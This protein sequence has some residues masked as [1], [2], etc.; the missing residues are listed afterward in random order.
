MKALALMSGGLDST[1]AA[2]MIL[3]QGIEIEGVNFTSPFCLCNRKGRCEAKD[4]AEKLNIN[5]YVINVGK[6]YLNIIKNPKHGYGKNMN[7]CIDC[8]IFI[9]KKAKAI[10]K[11][12]GASFIFTGEVLDER[13]MSQRLHALKIIEKEAGLEGKILRPLSAKCLPET[14][15]EKKGWVDRRK[16]LNFKGRSRKNQIQLANNLGIKDYRCPAGGCLL[17]QKEFA[18]KLKDL[19]NHKKRIALKDI[20]LLKL[21]RHFRFGQNKI[22]VGRN[23]SENN[24]LKNLKNRG[25]WFFEAQGCGSPVTVLQGPKTKKAVKIAAS[26]TERYSDAHA[27]AKQ[28]EVQVKYGNN[29]LDQDIIVSSKNLIGKTEYIPLTSQVSN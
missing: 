14:E 10:A 7:P 29:D 21:G 12:I 24:Q 19:F 22:I 16:L 15:A 6:E 9:L 23:Q 2:K 28:K 11:K 3:D 5:C 26:L 18:I 17:T 13:P 4:M 8:R 20:F 27:R 1:L 25:D